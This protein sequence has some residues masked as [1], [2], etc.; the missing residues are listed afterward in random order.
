MKI[1]RI[2]HVAIA[3]NNIAQMRDIFENKL[4]IAM[5]YEEHIPKYD[6]TLAMFLVGEPHLELL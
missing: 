4:G 2:E 5:E 3:V 1:K 6:T